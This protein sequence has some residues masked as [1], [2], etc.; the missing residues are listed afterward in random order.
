MKMVSVY[1]AVDGLVWEN[2]SAQPQGRPV[3]P[4]VD[5]SDE[6]ATTPSQVKQAEAEACDINNIMKRY[7]R[8]GIID[9]VNKYQGR[10]DDVA[11]AVDYHTALNIAHRA[12]AMFMT[13]P[14]S[15]RDRF[16]NDPGAFLEFAQDPKN[17]DAMIE[18]GL[19]PAKEVPP[20]PMDVRIIE[21]V[22]RKPDP[23]PSPKAS[24]A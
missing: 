21:T 7:E 6:L 10:Y 17:L 24:P 5:C 20:G 1:T 19:A 2:W 8:D 4:G 16:N 15:V 9:H 23:T 22:D 14:A 3:H 13:L 12:D 18:M 11:D